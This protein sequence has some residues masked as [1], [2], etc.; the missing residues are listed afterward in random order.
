[1]KS[2]LALLA[3]L[4]S[5][6]AFV[7]AGPSAGA[8]ATQ[9]APAAGYSAAQT[10]VA[11]WSTEAR[12]AIVPPGPAGVFGAENFGNKFPGEAA[13][14]MG[15]V[16]AAIYDAAVAIEGG[17]RPYA[18]TPRAPADTSPE[19]AVATAAYGTVIGL[20]PALGLNASQ[21]A[22]LD[23]DYAAYLAAVPDN[24]AK[25]N[26]ISVGAQ[27]AQAV[28][29]RRVNDGR[30]CSTTLPELGP[31]APAAGV[32]QPNATG[33]VLGLCLP[34]MRPLALRRG[35]QF[36]PGPP[37]RLT[38]G[39]YA[40]DFDQVKELGSAAS[41]S[42]TPEQTAQ[43]RFWT[44][45]DIRQWNDGMLRLAADGGLDLVQTARMLAMAHVAGGDAMIA[46][47]DA[48]YHYWFWRPFQAIPQADADGNPATVADPSWQPLG[49]TP[50]FPEYPSAHACHSAA[51]VRALDTF[52]GTDRVPLALDSRITHA[53]RSYGRLH[54]VVDDVD[55]ARV[56]VGFH[57]LTSDLRGSRLGRRVGE[58]VAEHYFQP[59][60]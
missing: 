10:P 45:H 31:P 5:A 53:T 60:G 39:A 23:G 7:G 51:V 14:Y 2:R 11:F 43:A 25:L 21:L 26:G 13:V 34:G 48:K 18:P 8:P 33:P 54:E 12:C 1:V 47:F 24:A 55:L 30:G 59:T 35:S 4:L 16:H 36:R 44:D 3:A 46:C 50:N 41:T 38:S 40:A 49:A 52:F 37:F 29:A 27:A 57:F 32:W 6:F 22:I 20:Q 58:Y 19:A 28:L 15:I 9:C 42:R 17:Y 56:L